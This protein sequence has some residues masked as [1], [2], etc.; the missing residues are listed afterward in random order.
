MKNKKA[1][2]PIIGFTLLILISVT[3]GIYTYNW[4][5]NEFK[6]SHLSKIESF[7]IK[8]IK[9]LDITSNNLYI[10]NLND[11]N[12]EITN[13]KIADTKCNITQTLAKNTI[14]PLNL[15]Y[16]TLGMQTGIKSITTYTHQGVFTQSLNVDEIPDG[17]IQVLF[18]LGT[19]CPDISWHEVYGLETLNNSHIETY[20]SNLYTYTLCLKHPIYTLNRECT[21]N[22]INLFYLPNTYNAHFWFDNS[23]APSEPVSNYYNWQQVCLSSDLGTFDLQLSTSQPTSDHKCIG[24]YYNHSLNGGVMG[25]CDNGFE[26]KIWI[27]LT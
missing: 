4:Y 20:N 22:Y 9:I 7:D 13:I 18:N 1:L 24:S 14:T 17:N 21:G 10:K 25:D 3:M 27:K 16:C 6:S 23:T 12:I 19:S 11:I 15:N 26:D 2:A 5:N 8:K